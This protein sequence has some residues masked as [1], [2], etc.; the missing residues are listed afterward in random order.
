M[1]TGIPFNLI[2]RPANKNVP[3]VNLTLGASISDGFVK[4][5]L[6]SSEL[7]ANAADRRVLI[8]LNRV[9]NSYKSYVIMTGD[10]KWRGMDTNGF[11]I[12]RNGSS[13]DRNFSLELLRQIFRNR[14]NYQKVAFIDEDGDRILG[15]EAHGALNNKS[16]TC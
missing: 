15:Y 14:K 3:D 10:E 2:G 12:G 9:N 11:S 13:L 7:A 6:I 1:T 8:R 4:L 16:T 5:Y